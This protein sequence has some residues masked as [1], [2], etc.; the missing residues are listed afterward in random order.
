M[1]I[2][3]CSASYQII[4]SASTICNS[5]KHFLSTSTSTPFPKKLY[6]ITMNFRN[7]GFKS[8]SDFIF[9]IKYICWRGRE[10]PKYDKWK[11]FTLVNFASSQQRNNFQNTFN[12]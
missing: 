1:N 12:G 2:A 5:Y 7:D 6:F 10:Y 4:L 3:D 9:E 8:D 11:L